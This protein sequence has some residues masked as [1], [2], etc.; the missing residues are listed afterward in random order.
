MVGEDKTKTKVPNIE[1]VED[2]S[3]LN[4]F[5]KQE[6]FLKDIPKKLQKKKKKENKSKDFIRN[7]GNK[8]EEQTKLPK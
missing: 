4:E 3:L 2:N 8:K 6:N 1:D 7:K 5:M